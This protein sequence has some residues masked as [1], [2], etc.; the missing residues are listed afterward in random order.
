MELPGESVR[1]PIKG[2]EQENRCMTAIT[3][4]HLMVYALSF[5]ALEYMK[6][7]VHLPI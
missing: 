4:G 2:G 5:G 3:N 6:Y 7:L 1:R